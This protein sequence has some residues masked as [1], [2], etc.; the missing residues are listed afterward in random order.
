MNSQ[1][2]QRL[3]R[4]TLGPGLAGIAAHQQPAP[5]CIESVHAIPH[6]LQDVEVSLTKQRDRLPTRSCVSGLDQA[7]QWR[8]ILPQVG[9]PRAEEVIGTDHGEAHRVL[10]PIPNALGPALVIRRPKESRVRGD[11]EG[12]IV[13][14]Q[15]KSVNVNRA[16]E[17]RTSA[18]GSGVTVPA[19]AGRDDRECNE[20]AK[21]DQQD[22]QVQA[23][24][25]NALRPLLD[26][27]RRDAKRDEWVDPP[28]AEQRVGEQAVQHGDG[29]VSICESMNS[30]HH[31]IRGQVPFRVFVPF[32]T[33]G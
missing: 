14:I 29:E 8:Q 19:A 12:A 6:G 27:D 10:C 30:L 7:E 33:V 13:W 15:P 28:Q 23:S 22:A 24:P 31:L 21:K 9:V 5:A 1:A 18:R 2:D 32:A 25:L 11:E 3:G 17:V 4:R 26:C 20:H 16:A